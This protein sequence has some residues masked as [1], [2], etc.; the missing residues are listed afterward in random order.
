MVDANDGSS[1]PSLLRHSY[2]KATSGW[3]IGSESSFRVVECPP[4]PL[5]AKKNLGI[6]APTKEKRCPIETSFCRQRPRKLG[7]E[8][9]RTL[10]ETVGRSSKHTLKDRSRV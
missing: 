10:A 8:K 7:C 2:C 5:S 6:S 1:S 9:R 4:A 3:S